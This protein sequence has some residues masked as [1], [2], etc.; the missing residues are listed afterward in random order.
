VAVKRRAW[1]SLVATSFGLGTPLT[2]QAQGLRTTL[3]GVY[4]AEQ[5]A[6]GR[7]RYQ[8]VCSEC[9]ALDYYSGATIRPWAGADVYSMYNLI[10]TQMPQNNPGSLRPREY[11]AM[12]AYIL[13]LNGMPAGAEALSS[14]RSVLQNIVFKWT[15]EG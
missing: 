8:R 13:E 11:V 1:L 3:D 10:R 6:L 7:Q 15:D 4:T 5:A 9:H 14:R 2:G 12:I